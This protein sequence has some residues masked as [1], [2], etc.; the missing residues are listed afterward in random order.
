[1]RSWSRCRDLGALIVAALLLASGGATP[2]AQGRSPIFTEQVGRVPGAALRARARRVR[3]VTPSRD[4]L[5][6]LM[7]RGGNA[8]AP[9]VLNLF[10]DT[11]LALV[12]E[13]I[14]DGVRGHRTWVGHVDGE[15]DS[16]VALTWDGS[17]LSGGVVSRG[18]AYDL[19]PAGAG[20]VA[21]VER[22]LSTTPREL[23]ALD[24]TAMGVA[25]VPVPEVRPAD[26][27]A[28]IDLLV[29]YTPAARDL[30]GGTAAIVAQLANAV[31]VTNTALV[32]SGID[33][34]V[35]AVGVDELP[36]AESAS[37]VRGDL[38]TIEPGGPMGDLVAA[39][40]DGRDA[41]LVALVTGRATALDACGIARLGPSSGAA[42]S[43]SEQA[44]LFAGQ[45]SFTHELGH[46]F[47]AN[48]A[49]GDSPAGFPG[50]ARAYR[51]GPIRT[52]LA[53]ALPESPPRLLNFSSATVREP[54]GVGLP[55][56]NSLQDNA[57]QIRESVDVVASFR[58]QA[59]LPGTPIG[60]G[61]VITGTR[62]TL[63]W[64]PPAGGALVS[65]YEL[66]VGSIPGGADVLRAPVAASPLDVP[67]VGLGTYYARLRSVGP[68]GRSAPTPDL[69][70]VVG[71]CT[72]PGAIVLAGQGG[73]GGVT[74]AWTPATGSA[75]FTYGIGAGTVPGALDVG[76]FP[77]GAATSVTVRPAR[78]VYYVRAV[79]A[80]A[81]GLGPIS[82]EIQ[83][84]VP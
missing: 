81:C 60:L 15:P 43:V 49:P 18:V 22:D 40:R 84:T 59:R 26:T 41:D 62:V 80:N 12:R 77:I 16:T 67:G 61:A 3:Q 55:T 42:F 14:E 72:L 70:V 13:R 6:R 24:A 31:A 73:A 28:A 48:H 57:R 9:F 65:G 25:G 30:A 27:P 50:Y 76:V 20:A 78:G 23:A 44:C 5:Q 2:Q 66:E 19:V 35:T 52:L 39:L 51:E 63:S 47:G 34:V 32:R 33:A 58:G 53:Y 1:M 11:A 8:R 37:G 7:Q 75:P 21:V 29:L 71:Q 82:N 69:T 38:T 54:A 68:T 83:V 17:T 64:Q 36:Y 79:A 45:W 74:L 56:G 10:A 4:A 46:A